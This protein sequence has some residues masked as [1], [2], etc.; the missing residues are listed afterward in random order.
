MYGERTLA[1]PG[2][3]LRRWEPGRS[4]LGAALAKGW[5]EPIPRPGERWLYLGASTGTTTS[6]VADLVGPEGRVYSLERSIRPFARLL[7]LSEKYPNI[8]PI[9]GDARH[10]EEYLGSVPPVDGV[11]VDV[12]QADQ[13]DIAWENARHFLRGS[14]SLLLALKTSSMGRT[15]EPRAHLAAAT[16]R[17][18]VGFELLPP[19]G[20]DPFHRRHY[21]VGGLA[22]R[23]LYTEELGRATTTASSPAVRRAGRR[24]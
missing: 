10:P 12:A 23:R 21:L 6:H 9:L 13:V 19:V 18:T 5:I 20:L 7:S 2:G 15:M 22:T 17:L 16:E 8:L 24:R 14:G 4:K 3:T 1:V 11:Y